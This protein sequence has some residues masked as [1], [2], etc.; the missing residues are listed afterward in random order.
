MWRLYIQRFLIGRLYSQY[1]SNLKN[2]SKGEIHP[3][4]WSMFLYTLFFIKWGVHVFLFLPF[5]YYTI[6]S[7]HFISM[8]IIGLCPQHIS[9]LENSLVVLYT[10][11]I[12]W[13]VHIFNIFHYNTIKSLHF[14]LMPI[15]RLYPQYISTLKT[16]I[17]I[18]VA[19]FFINWRVYIFYKV[20][21]FYEVG[22]IFLGFLLNKLRILSYN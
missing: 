20:E 6:K 18:I 17:Q 11:F 2:S 15:I 5:Y 1:I 16:N 19:C 9:N 14:I 12:K 22:T 4:S 3:N 13:R 10:I 8:P 21:T 7:L